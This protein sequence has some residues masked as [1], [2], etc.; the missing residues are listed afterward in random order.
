MAEDADRSTT[1]DSELIYWSTH[2]DDTGNSD[3]TGS[4]KGTSVNVRGK[5]REDKKQRQLLEELFCEAEK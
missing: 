2:M 1:K 3:K 5:G 4:N